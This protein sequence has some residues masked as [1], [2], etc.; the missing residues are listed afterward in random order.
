MSPTIVVLFD[1]FS[2]IFHRYDSDIIRNFGYLRTRTPEELPNV[3]YHEV[4]MRKKKFAAWFVSNCGSMTMSA[5]NEYVN[6]LRKYI[7]IDVYGNCG[8]MVANRTEEVVKRILSEYKF[9]L[10]FENSFCTDYVTEK[11]FLYFEISD[12]VLVVRGGA[13]YDQLLPKY[14]HINAQHFSNARDLGLYLLSLDKNEEEYTTYLKTRDKYEV[15]Q[16][17]W[18]CNLCIKLNR[19]QSFAKVYDDVVGWWHR[20]KC[21]AATDVIITWTARRKWMATF[22]FLAF[23]VTSFIYIRKPSDKTFHFSIS[24]LFNRKM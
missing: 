23:I 21:W 9:F 20:D 12:A 7:P 4:F 11:F 1:L 18:A 13:D 6:E 22:L 14:T 10:S 17:N 2:F 24:Y 15:L 8:T 5:R 3:D 19:K 16:M